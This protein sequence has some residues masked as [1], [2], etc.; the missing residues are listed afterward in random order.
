M[1][2]ANTRA[3]IA[4]RIG[5][6]RIG[7]SAPFIVM[8]GRLLAW[9]AAQALFAAFFFFQGQSDPW[10]A[11][12]PW[13]SVYAVVANLLTL[14]LLA[15]FLR[16]EGIGF[17]DLIGRIRL[18]WGQDLWLT[19]AAY[20]VISASVMV[21][22]VWANWLMF[23]MDF[24]PLYPGLLSDRT[25]PLWGV[26]VSFTLFPALNAVIEEMTF[27]GFALARLDG[28]MRQRWL[29]PLI[30]GVIWSLQ[31]AF[32]PFILDWRYVAWRFLY[33]IAGT[34]AFCLV[35]LVVRRIV[36]LILPHA[37]MDG[38]AVFYTLRF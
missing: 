31:H 35:Y 21:P 36:P 17:S 9:I 22:A 5:A 14:P 28:L 34:L 1:G 29:A 27:N 23:G 37:A 19:I 4:E 16:R 33:F 7:L 38:M 30:V 24:P 10:A 32:L 11:A 2:G 8:G 12:A 25:L 13:W 18:K 26:V 20:V 6:G 15:V 3:A